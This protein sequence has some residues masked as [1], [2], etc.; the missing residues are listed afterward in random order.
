MILIII[1]IFVNV[2]LHFAVIQRRHNFPCVDQTGI[3]QLLLGCEECMGVKR[4]L[5]DFLLDC[6]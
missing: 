2:T 4:E 1:F 3:F 5:G 6:Q